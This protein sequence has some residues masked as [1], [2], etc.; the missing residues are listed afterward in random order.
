MVSI[1]SGYMRSNASSDQNKLKLSSAYG[2]L[3]QLQFRL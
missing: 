3:F 2:I 1:E